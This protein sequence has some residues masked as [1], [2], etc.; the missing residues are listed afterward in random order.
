LLNFIA[1]LMVTSRPELS[2]SATT[3]G[4]GQRAIEHATEFA[5]RAG[6][7][8]KALA[9]ADAVSQILAELRL[10]P[11]VLAAAVL[12]VASQG[13]E[14]ALDTVRSSFGPAVAKLVEGVSRMAFLHDMAPKPGPGSGAHL[15]NLRKMLL[16]MAEDVR[17]VLIKLAERLYV[18]RSLKHRPA[19]QREAVARETLTIFAP[20][21]NR[22]GIGQI[23]WELEDL[24]FRYLEPERYKHIAGL[25]DERRADRERYI[26]RVVKRLGAELAK[27]GI[28]AEVTG[29][30]KHIYSIWRKMQRKSVDFYQLFDVRALRVLVD[31]IADCYA[32]LGVVH[33]LW[34]H[35]P[36]EFDDYIATPKENQY[37]SLHT[38]VRGPEGKTLE[39]Q[40]RTHDMNQHADLGVAAHW[41]YKEGSRYDP[42][43]ERRIAWLRQLLE[44]K[45]ERDEAGDLLEQ[46][47][48]E[49]FHERVYVL[50]PRGEI[51]DLPQG[52]TPLDFAYHIHTQ[53]GHCCRG[54]KVNGRIV[55]LNHELRSGDAVE[56]LTAK[57]GG[58]SRDWLS[59]HLGYLKSGR[60]RGRVRQWFKQQD[61]EKTQASGR[62][63]LERELRRLGMAGMSYE[64]LASQAGFAKL[65]DFLAAL[66]RGDLSATQVAAS[67]HG[68]VKPEPPAELRGKR[69]PVETGRQLRV[70]GVGN[71][72]TNL[73]G[74]CK[75]L[76]G[77]AVIG[78]ITRGRGVSV[79]RRDCPNILRLGEGSDGRLI[80]VDWGGQGA[81][82]YPVDL[83]VDAFDRAGLLRDIT[84]ILAD[85]RI[86]VIAVNT[87]SSRGQ[88]TAHMS[89]TVEVSD[90]YQL[91]R[92][93]SR[94]NQV[95]NV[96]DARRSHV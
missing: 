86:N 69:L 9:E 20:L 73:A 62:A 79:H 5:R 75:P 66:G 16:A 71:L 48:A 15:E 82:T 8:E 61:L 64:K 40:I 39:V 56:V 65:D 34:P 49:A 6:A 91:S 60:A 3:P 42:G 58:P 44:W 68:Q 67:V 1:L 55:P 45:G 57:Q 92:V 83:Q 14:F 43:F 93:L 30:P 19:D 52:A 18:M 22:L 51:V 59:P 46:F 35:V 88:H 10:D 12:C 80:E 63:A 37:R 11:E 74:C 70:H 78:Y 2:P 76:P 94:I 28:R 87:L 7:T 25:L 33:T 13:C 24:A 27:A 21:A 47:K 72:L 96:T 26:A 81:G 89:L 53:V 95:P 23:K 85:E 4:E 84:A 50:T 29:R 77:D 32:A 38:A 41:R 90:I 17:V 31:E 36:G 54:A